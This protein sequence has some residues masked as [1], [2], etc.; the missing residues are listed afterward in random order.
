MWLVGGE[1]MRAGSGEV[2]EPRCGLSDMRCC[3]WGG[4]PLGGGELISG[5]GGGGG[6]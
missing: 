2:I 3:M 1:D 5:G 6:N 4:R